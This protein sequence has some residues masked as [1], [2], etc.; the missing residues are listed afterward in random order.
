MPTYRVKFTA[1]VDV[2]VDPMYL[3]DPQFDVIQYAIDAAYERVDKVIDRTPIE[4]GE[5]MGVVKLI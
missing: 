4:F 3:D 5:M 2:D 1:S